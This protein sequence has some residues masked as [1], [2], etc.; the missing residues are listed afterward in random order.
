LTQVTARGGCGIEVGKLSGQAESTGIIS[1]NVINVA[2]Y[3]GIQ[4]D[5]SDNTS[6]RFVS[7][8]NL[9][10]GP[11]YDLEGSGAY[12]NSG[13]GSI[14]EIG[15]ISYSYNP[16]SI[17]AAGTET[18]YAPLPGLNSSLGVVSVTPNRTL[19]GLVLSC[20]AWENYIIL[21]LNN[22]S[23]GAVDLGAT[24]FKAI[25]GQMRASY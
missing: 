13:G 17:A 20:K 12:P 2:A 19:D 14:D 25:A 16:S 9:G 5:T 1:N 4:N 18:F 24:S 23:A 21:Q 8:V 7:N 15:A 10:T 22:P 11:L 3:V 6:L